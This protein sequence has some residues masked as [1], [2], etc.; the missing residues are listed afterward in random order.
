MSL[1][2]ETGF[3]WIDGQ[4]YRLT[5]AESHIVD[6]LLRHHLVPSSED[7]KTHIKRIRKKVPLNIETL[8]GRG[9][10]LAMTDK[11]RPAEVDQTLT[12]AKG[13]LSGEKGADMSDLGLTPE[14]RTYEGDTGSIKASNDKVEVEIKVRPKEKT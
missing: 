6:K 5:T 4:R 10:V 2:A 8:W 1:D 12:R 11:P 14:P 3:L 13:V 7:V 9:Y